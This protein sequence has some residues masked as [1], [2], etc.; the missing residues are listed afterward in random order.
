MVEAIDF[1][2]FEVKESAETPKRATCLENRYLVAMI[3][4]PV[5]GCQA[6]DAATNNSDM[7]LMMTIR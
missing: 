2:P 4:E 1:A 6:G 7:Q 3:G 5:S